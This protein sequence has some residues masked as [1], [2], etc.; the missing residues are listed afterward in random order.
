M[1]P[2]G[3]SH[4][5]APRCFRGDVRVPALRRTCH[6]DHGTRFPDL[7]GARRASVCSHPVPDRCR[8]PGPARWQGGVVEATEHVEIV[9]T[10][11]PVSASLTVRQQFSRWVQHHFVECEHVR[12]RGMRRSSTTSTSTDQP[13]SVGS[14]AVAFC[15]FDGRQPGPGR[16]AT[17]PLRVSNRL[18]GTG[19]YRARAA[20]DP[21]HDPRSR[22]GAH[23]AWDL[24]LYTQVAL[25]CDRSDR[26]RV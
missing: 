2:P 21:A 25:F 19:P 1:G 15:D 10:T 5:A 11:A 9:V 3:A 12:R 6:T 18:C 8:N 20:D 23:V 7:S 24:C 13:P 4:Q 14:T 16:R 22:A 17:H 26:G